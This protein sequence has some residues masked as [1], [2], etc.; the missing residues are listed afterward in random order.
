[1][2]REQQGDVLRA[3]VVIAAVYGY[4]LI[5]AQ[6]AFLDLL[7][8]AAVPSG[9]MPS[10]LAAMVVGGVSGGFVAVWRIG[11]DGASGLLRHA[12]AAAALV[13]ALSLHVHGTICAVLLA[14]ATGLVLGVATV[15]LAAR[16][17]EWLRG[18]RAPLWVGVGTGLAYAVCNVPWLFAATPVV[19]AWAACV[20]ALVGALAV[21][22]RREVAGDSSSAPG[23][24]LWPWILVFFALVW[25]DSA[26]FWVIQHHAEFKVGTWVGEW[27]LW[28][29]AA[30]HLGGGLVAGCWLARGGLRV[31]M[32][33]SLGLLSV[34]GLAVNAGDTREL[35]GLLYPLAVSLYSTALAAWPG[36][37]SAAS[38]EAARARTAAWLFAVA[39]W[40]GSANGIGMA[41]HLQRVPPTVVGGVVLV[42]V[43][44]LG[45]TGLIRRW[46]ESLAVGLVGV[47]VAGGWP[48]RDESGESRPA[49]RGREV[50]V[51]EGCIHCHSRYVRSATADEVMWGPATLAAQAVH[52][53]PV[54][55][56]NRRHG[57]DLTNV[58]GRRSEAWLRLHFQ[59]PRALNSR[60]VMPG[61]AHLF[62]DRR[63]ADLIAFLRV[64][65]AEASADVL[66]RAMTWR[67]DLDRYPPDPERGAKVFQRHCAACH[68]PQ[69]KGDGPLAREF[70]KAPANLTNGPFV[71]SARRPDEPRA[72]TVAR[73]VR[74]G[75]PG[76]DM[77][78]HETMAEADVIAV[79]RWVADKNP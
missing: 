2:R 4:F 16:L 38:T 54:L 78:G 43:F 1:M 42:V 71:W 63:G 48:R 72:A 33:A 56:G 52:E 49:V 77:P 7:E 12:L 76:T 36:L 28:R 23:F 46:R 20:M 68:G 37:L 51:A 17:R 61:Y 11:R 47:L 45:R 13:A 10:V 6:F 66:R 22:P 75:L 57:P 53:S 26:A 65:A 31:M 14:V 41:T 21:P 40:I 30:V 44:V 64:G 19:Q 24:R 67:P 25:L 69:A 70:A 32:L 60:S 5:F 8:K 50:Y 73:I 59:N 74:S 9:L 27:R 15:A 58:G 79:A 18:P 35:G 3:T 62:A 34:A 29:N 55:I 39:G